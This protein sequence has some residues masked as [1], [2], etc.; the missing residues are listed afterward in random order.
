M[1]SRALRV[2]SGVTRYGW[3]PAVRWPAPARASSDP[4]AAITR[5]LGG[6]RRRRGIEPVEVLG[7]RGDRLL[8]RARLVDVVDERPVADADAAQEPRP[9]LG[10]EAGVLGRGLLRRVHP[11]VEDARS[12]SSPWSS[13][14]A[15]C[16]AARTG[17]RRRPGSTAPSSRATRARPRGSPPPPG[18][19]SAGCCSRCRCRTVASSW[20]GSLPA[21]RVLVGVGRARPRRPA[22]REH[23][24]TT[25][26]PS[27]SRSPARRPAHQRTCWSSSSAKRSGRQAELVDDAR[28]RCAP[29]TSAHGAAAGVRR[30]T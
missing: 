23:A 24:G 11:H 21:S 4:S 30:P 26:T 12:R 27:C 7:H 6:E 5:S 8:V 29:S 3:V 13:R 22:R 25:T 10:G 18:R 19:R 17:R 2:S 28:R 16:R 9:V 15:G 1:P 14:R 20:G